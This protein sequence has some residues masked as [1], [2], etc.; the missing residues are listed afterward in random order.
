MTQEQIDAWGEA[1]DLDKAAIL[2]T[3]R[4][5]IRHSADRKV[6]LEKQFPDGVDDKLLVALI[7][8]RQTAELAIE[9]LGE[10]VEPSETA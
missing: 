3:L 5:H 1:P 4:A 9:I 2:G 10:E 8:R 6:Q 7:S